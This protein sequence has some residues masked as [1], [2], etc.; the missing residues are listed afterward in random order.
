MKNEKKQSTTER[1]IVIRNAFNIS[2]VSFVIILF[3]TGYTFSQS[4]WTDIGPGN[5]VTYGVYCHPTDPNIIYLMVDTG[6]LYRTMDRGDNWIRISQSVATAT[7]P[8]RQYRGGEHAVAVDPRPGHGNVVYFSPGQK[9][10][11]GLWRST[12]YGTTWTKTNGDNNLGASAVA[13]DHN[14][15]VY[16]ISGD[17]R[18]YSSPDSGNTWTSYPYPFQITNEWYDAQNMKCDIDITTNN[19]IWVDTR[20][21]GDGIF[22]TKDGGQTWS[23]K[24]QGTWIVDLTCSPVDSNLILALEQD[25]RIFRSDDGGENFSQ[26]GSVQQNNYWSFNTWPPHRGGIT[27]NR[28]GIVIAIGRY[29]MARSTDG[30]QTFTETPES[31]LNYSAPTWPFVDR[32]NTDQAL[33][34]CDLSSSPV[35]PG[36]FVYGDGAMVKESVDS[37]LTWVGG[38]NKG[39]N[40]LWE[41][42]N[43]YFDADDPNVFHVAMVDNG[44]FYTTDLGQTWHT[45]ETDR[46]SC[47]GVTQDPNNHNV[48]YKITKTNGGTTL[49]VYKSTDRGHHFT[50]LTSVSM[51]D[52][53]YGGR[54]FV[55]P[56]DSNIIY[57]TIRGGKGVYK[58]TDGGNSFTVVYPIQNIHQSAITKS[59]NVF[60]HLWNGSGGLYRYL[61]SADQW[62]NITFGYSVMGFAVDPNDENVIFFNNNNGYLYKT[63]NGLSDSP[64]WT[65]LDYYNGQQLYID[66]YVPRYMLMMTGT[67]GLGMIIS[68]DGGNSWEQFNDN[69][70]TSFVWGFVPG[71]P[72]AK[73]R[74]YAFDATAYYATIYDS[75]VVSVNEETNNSV[76]QTFYLGNSYPNPFNLSTYIPFTVGSK[77]GNVR[78]VIYNLLGQKIRTLVNGNM[79]SGQHE[80]V[81]NG[82][83]DSGEIVN[84]GIYLVRLSSANRTLLGKIVLLK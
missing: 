67:A 18:I 13:V 12:D 70:G 58:S 82:K 45:S 43:P 23:Q 7:M 25:G 57:I 2:I 21:N 53:T 63:T 56:T 46:I 34:C 8:Q 51:N 78:L 84:S 66:P 44:H 62:K 72:A 39:V 36:L 83:N 15:V 16:C 27:I 9:T 3:I 24:L 4:K 64:T 40:G 31:S 33:K 50:Q 48:Y 77:S 17:L 28:A 35:D 38:K 30:G 65:K 61:K 59:G 73:G 52:D 6:H 54:I 10:N 80:I 19:D 55:D 11:A 47:Q 14:A 41:Y 1:I 69:L 71:G 5:G 74:V 42:G 76:P 79:S 81:W 75:T 20:L 26:T 32:H 60:F 37:G 68:R 22:Y 29:S 49:G